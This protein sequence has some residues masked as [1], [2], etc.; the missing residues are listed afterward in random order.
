MSAGVALARGNNTIGIASYC[1]KCSLMPVKVID[2]G[3]AGS[4]ASVSGGITW[5]ADHGAK[6]IS[7]SLGFS[8]DSST[9]QSAVSYART[10]G[11]L[12]IA[13][14]GNYGTSAK[15]YP[16]SDVGTIGVAGTDGNNTL[17][18]WSS[19]GSQ[20][21]L[22]A[23]AAILRQERTLG[24]AHFAAHPAPRRRP[25]ALPACFCRLVVTLRERS[26]ECLNDSG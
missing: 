1:W 12:V 21:K 10:K 16:A 4:F 2:S 13:S 6:V 24:M 26:R 23:P 22:A 19:Y 17:Y 9:L 11:T 20:I 3:G 14:A 7:M 18:S 5:A 25:P 8:S 15:I